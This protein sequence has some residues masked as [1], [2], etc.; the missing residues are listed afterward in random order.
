MASSSS[1][2]RSESSHL[3]T[4]AP[5]APRS[6][7]RCPTAALM[8]SV[9][10]LWPAAWQS[11]L[12]SRL[13]RT[14]VALIG[15]ILLTAVWTYA[16]AAAP[17]SSAAD[18]IAAKALEAE[19][20]K[21]V[22]PLMAPGVRVGNVKITCP[23]AA[24]TTLK[25]VAP[26]ISRLNS[27]IFMVEL[28]N[29]HHARLCGVSLEAQKQ[30]LVASHALAAAQPV[31]AEDFTP[32]WVDAFTGAPGASSSF[33]FSG[34]LVTTTFIGAGQPLYPTELAKPTAGRP[35]DMVTVVVKNGAITVKAALESRTTASIGDSATMLNPET[36]T[37]VQIHVTGVR[38]GELVM[39]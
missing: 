10:S 36:G 12:Q 17:I 22:A 34:P 8:L 33:D 7:E 28:E 2:A 1:A 25:D 29:D 13:V 16:H 35:G 4:V 20:A 37:A 14:V 30:V 31:A 18:P 3:N 9:Q 39:R 11:F 19:I 27:R 38:T 26:G 15:A 32:G 6:A 21:R 23:V 5:R 24:G